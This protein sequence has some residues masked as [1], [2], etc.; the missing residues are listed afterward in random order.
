VGAVGCLI[1]SIAPWGL[2]VSEGMHAPSW[3]SSR[4]CSGT[5]SAAVSLLPWPA[6]RHPTAACC[7]P[8]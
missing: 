2:Q 1:K 5:P 6:C 8:G 3:S 4:S 7:L